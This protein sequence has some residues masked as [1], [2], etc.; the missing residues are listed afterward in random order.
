LMKIS[1]F[2]GCIQISAI[3]GSIT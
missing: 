1:P 3:K 2:S